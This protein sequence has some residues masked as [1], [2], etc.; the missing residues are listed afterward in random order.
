MVKK[1]SKEA[2]SRKNELDDQEKK[3]NLLLK[4]LVITLAL[5][6]FAAWALTLKNS[7]Q[8]KKNNKTVNPVITEIK[9][10]FNETIEE[11][12]KRVKEAEERQKLEQGLKDLVDNFQEEAG[13]ELVSPDLSQ[14]DE[15][16][17][18]PLP[19]LENKVRS[20]CPQWI[21]CMPIIDGPARP[22]QIPS[23][24]EGYTQLVY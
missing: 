8:L 2:S 21:N 12:L 13:K 16:L 14:P 5:L 15:D 6:I 18:I 4:F 10:D 24:C 22:C 7:W 19:V 17:I 20:D 11:V 1:S 23:G 9:K 3:K